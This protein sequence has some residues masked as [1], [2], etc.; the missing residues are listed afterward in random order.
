M[1]LVGMILMNKILVVEDN[2][3]IDNG[4]YLLDYKK[5]SNIKI[6]GSVILDNY[7]K[8]NYYL[9]IE[10]LNNINLILNK[11]NIIEDNLKINITLNNDSILEYNMYVIN[12]GINKV[13]INIEMLGN[14][15]K[16]IIKLRVINK[17]SDSNLDIICNGKVKENTINNELLEDLK[18]LIVSTDSIKISPNMEINTNEVIANH[19]VTIGSFNKDDLFYLK[20][21]GLSEELARK[22]LL[23]NFI[24]SNL[25][26]DFKE[27]I[28][29]EV[30]NIE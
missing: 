6:D 2:I 1:L 14:N 22:I 3:K 23:K 7:S 19:L 29:M 9:N 5:E 26:D 16:A 21:K 20:S 30:I 4:K 15:N 27:K 24:T 18:G 28:K 11:V 13:E 8:N 12:K 25:N 10:V 17:T